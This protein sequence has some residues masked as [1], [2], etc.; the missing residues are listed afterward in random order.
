MIKDKL[1]IG[2]MVFAIGFYPYMFWASLLFPTAKVLGVTTYIFA[3]TLSI[4]VVF[5]LS[6]KRVFSKSDL[7]ILFIYLG[8]VVIFSLARTIIH[9][10]N[11]SLAS[12]RVVIMIFVYLG[13]ISSILSN[14]GYAELMTSIIIINV[15][16]QAVFG[17]IH[18]Y[19]FPHIVTGIALDDSGVGLYVIEQGEGGY[20]ENGMLLGSNV[21][22]N[23]LAAGLFLMLYALKNKSI[24]G[25][26][27]LLVSI[28]LT[29]WAIYLSGSRY[30]L[31]I[32]LFICFI[33]F[34]KSISARYFIV[35]ILFGG[36]F[37]KFTPI[38]DALLERTKSGGSGGRLDMFLL[39]IDM[40]TENPVNILIGVPY[41]IVATKTTSQGLLISDNSFMLVFTSYGSVIGVLFFLLL[42]Y[43][44]LK[45][46]RINF[47]TIAFL[48]F[49]VGLFMFNNAILWDIWLLYAAAILIIISKNTEASPHTD[50]FYHVAPK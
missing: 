47:G 12:Y 16:V 7:Y 23:F 24:K 32:A 11:T 48:V 22:G 46:I 29:I 34:F 25:K 15:I 21:F 45:K 18:T 13:A 39:S 19:Y 36:M 1:K 5:L 50:L 26:L 43:F 10:E 37:L 28:F 27:I 9:D 31:I 20:R 38:L 33:Y 4:V 44:I 41:R 35:P 30:A 17:I 6:F 40:I 8:I 2:L 49:T 14:R 42:F 3:I